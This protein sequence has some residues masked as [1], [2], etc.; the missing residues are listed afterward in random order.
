[1]AGAIPAAIPPPPAPG[2]NVANP[3]R[4]GPRQRQALGL[5]PL[6]GGGGNLPLLFDG[7]AASFAGLEAPQAG[8]QIRPLSLLVQSMVVPGGEKGLVAARVAPGQAGVPVP[9]GHGGLD[10]LPLFG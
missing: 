2:G 8:T 1:M 9:A 5:L 7:E 10:Q 4:T 3:R 6:P